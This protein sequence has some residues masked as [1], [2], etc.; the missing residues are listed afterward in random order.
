MSYK[1]YV[2]GHK[3]LLAHYN[4]NVKSS[5]ASMAAWGAKHW[6]KHGKGEIAAGTRKGV[7][8]G[9]GGG[10]AHLTSTGYAG[11][12]GGN[13]GGGGGGSGGST[14]ASPVGG[15]G[16]AGFCLVLTFP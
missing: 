6:A 8:P 9:G 5:G 13:Y 12:A 3:D 16:A 4:K 1:S 2:E 14:G 15:A 11:G 10:G 7:T